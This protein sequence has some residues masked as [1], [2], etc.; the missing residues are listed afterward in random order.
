MT[1]ESVLSIGQ[2]ALWVT[3]LVSSPLLMSALF[4]GLLIGMLQAATQINEMPLSFIP[5]LLVLGL[6]LLVAGPWIIGTIV[7][8][9]RGLILGIPTLIG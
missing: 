7:D 5:Q 2:Q 1:P 9:T 8:Y 3:F 4:I 6:S